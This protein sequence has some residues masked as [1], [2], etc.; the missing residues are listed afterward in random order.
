VKAGM[1]ELDRRRRANAAMFRRV[2]RCLLEGDER[3]WTDLYDLAGPLIRITL[4]SAGF[5]KH[6]R[7]EWRRKRTGGGPAVPAIEVIGPRPP[8]RPRAEILGVL[9]RAAGGDEGAMV[10]LREMYHFDPSGLIERCS[11][12]LAVRAW[13]AFS[14]RLGFRT[15]KHVRSKRGKHGGDP[16]NGREIVPA[17]LGGTELA[18]V[19]EKAKGGD[20]AAVAE[21]RRA[22]ADQPDRLIELGCGD[23]AKTVELVKVA[24]FAKDDD[25]RYVAVRAKMGQLRAELAGPRPS[26]IERLLADR[27][28]LCW[29]DCHATDLEAEVEGRKGIDLKVRAF[30][31]RRRERAHKRYLSALKV[32]AQVRKLALPAIQVNIGGQ[33]VNVAGS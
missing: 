5:R 11:K 12:W 1:D 27:A 17:A 21:I 7:G 19:A 15:P 8:L 20:K 9:E 32:L 24:R 3:I 25:L 10:R 14:T 23:L 31:D 33:Q 16:M 29:L 2:D 6:K 13:S 4:E 22:L 26:P 30:H 18:A 28:A